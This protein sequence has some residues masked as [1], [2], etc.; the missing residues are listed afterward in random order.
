MVTTSH[1]RIIVLEADQL[2]NAGVSSFLNA[3]ENF[4]VISLET[5]D[6]E[7]IAREIMKK[8]PDIII[9]GSKYGRENLRQLMQ[10][11][12]NFPHLRTIV[13]DLDENKIQV[14]EWQSRSITTL[15]DFLAAFR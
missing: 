4:E 6:I 8:Q 14:R 15:E 2:L 1:K 7:Q 12:D 9:M 13:V 11:L 3:Q 5:R 10:R